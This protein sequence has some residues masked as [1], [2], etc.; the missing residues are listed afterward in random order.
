M[1]EIL[2]KAQDEEIIQDLKKDEII[3]EDSAEKILDS[4][5]LNIA[6]DEN[7]RN[8]VHYVAQYGEAEQIKKLLLLGMDLN[9][10]DKW[11]N[12]P[13][14]LAAKRGKDIEL[15]EYILDYAAK[16]A[17]NPVND[18]LV[19]NDEGMNAL[20]I[21][22]ENANIPVIETLLKNNLFAANLEKRDL[23]GRT[24]LDI[25]IE[26]Q[27]DEV[28][29]LLNRNIVPGHQLNYGVVLADLSQDVL[30]K[31]LAHYLKIK[32]R[33]SSK[34]IQ[35][36][37]NCNGWSFIYQIFVTLGIE[38]EFYAL[39]N[40]LEEWDEKVES[41]QD[42]NLSPI[43]REKYKNPEDIMEYLIYL[44]VFFQS[45]AE[46]VK[47]L[48]LGYAQGDRVEQYNFIKDAIK[49]RE[50]R[51]IFTIP[52][53][54][55]NREQLI[56]M[57]KYFSQWKGLVVDIGGGKH[58]T[59]LS[60]TPDGKFKYFDPN[61]KNK[62]PPFDSAEELADHII[63]FKYKS[64]GK[65]EAD[66]TFKINYGAYKFYDKPEDVPVAETMESK[67]ESFYTAKSAY[68][69][70]PLHLAILANDQEKIET[71]LAQSYGKRD[72]FGATPLKW[73]V[74]M[75]NTSTI[76]NLIQLGINID[77]EDFQ[78][79]TALIIAIEINKP[80]MIQYLLD[81]KADVN[82]PN[83]EGTTPFIYS[84][85]NDHIQAIQ[86]LKAHPQ[87]NVNAQDN[88][89]GSALIYAVL[90][91]YKHVVNSLLEDDRVN[92]DLADYNGDT[93]L[94]HAVKEGNE[95]LVEILLEKN[96]DPNLANREKI[97]PLMYAALTGNIKMVK[98]I[99]DK[100]PDLNKQDADGASAL[101]GA[102]L[103]GNIEIVKILLQH[104][105]SPTIITNEN[106]TAKEYVEDN[107]T[108][109]QLLE[110]WERKQSKKHNSLLYHKTLHDQKNK[111]IHDIPNSELTP[112]VGPAKPQKI[113]KG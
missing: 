97:T 54:T 49:G 1:K 6:I 60:I 9:P 76:D 72:L 61:L 100:K 24:A 16:N 74:C 93:P 52:S 39:Q 106:K 108:L 95:A 8:L 4:K 43:L 46:A 21:A 89:G 38:D 12:T 5:N 30:N 110:K 102:A 48:N 58:N 92:V 59:S 109:V 56:E 86:L 14:H 112:E 3:P 63:K 15:V 13:L 17:D 68:G 70:T 28:I 73:A 34:I 10:T 94:M 7:E 79:K 88:S 71:F 19:T 27:L 64:L 2:L 111:S 29:T 90:N 47:E 66:G 51:N 37:G 77:D 85:K 44:L 50:I 98:L 62:I 23:Y 67:N 75:M 33:D 45:S 57:L 41:L 69:F 84:A 32:G 83:K 42:N 31:K 18:V 81:R 96:A 103:S 82:K 87:I 107:P 91:N 101:I 99:L 35:P 78:G 20:H 11:S 80:K 26:L 113:T 104:G 53:H 105:A 25:A 22:I 55:S 40:F 36:G 65:L